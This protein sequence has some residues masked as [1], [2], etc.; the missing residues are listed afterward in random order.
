M[1]DFT[2][3]KSTK[4]NKKYDAVF[5]DGRVVSFG[6]IG[7]DQYKDSALG[8]YKNLDHGD[9]KRRDLFKKRFEKLRHKK[10]SPSY[11]SDVYLWS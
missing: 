5:K 2:F 8:L 11:F 7:Y 1:S 3:R 4:K 9:L 10:F 6:Q